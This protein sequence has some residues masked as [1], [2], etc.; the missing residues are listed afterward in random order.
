MENSD[1]EKISFIPSL[2]N[3]GI[4]ESNIEFIQLRSASFIKIHEPLQSSAVI[5]LEYLDCED[6]SSSSDLDEAAKILY[7]SICCLSKPQAEMYH[8]S[9][10]SDKFCT[11][12]T[13]EYLILR[14]TESNVLKTPCLNHEC[15][16][17]F[18][19]E[20][21]QILLPPVFYQ[22]YLIFKRNEELNNCP[23][24]R[25]CPLPDCSGFDIGGLNQNKLT[26]NK[27][28][29]KFCYYCT[30]PWH[31]KT[32]CKQSNDKELDKWSK[33]HGV[34][35][36]PNCRRKVQKNSGCDHMACVKCR[37]EWCWLCGEK[38]SG[39]HMDQ[40]EVKK[41]HRW[42]P[43]ISYILML[44]FSTFAIFF[45]P[46]I[47]FII[48]FDKAARETQE[49]SGFKGFIRRRW[50]SFPFAVVVGLLFLPLYVTIGPFVA[51]I[52]FVMNA[53]R[54]CSNDYS[55]IY[56]VGLFLGIVATPILII[57]GFLALGIFEFL[58]CVYLI[59]KIYV[60]IR[61]CINPEFL[62]PKG[63]YGNN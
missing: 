32:K 22:K 3:R 8:M 1:A 5:P 21:L 47:G 62:R 28:H 54:Q 19:D 35:Y 9:Q 59:I 27:C 60:V 45:M 41:T 58:G 4:D 12:C 63:G 42:N 20:E 36:C 26:C 14:V 18:T 37:Y 6:L 53:L 61:K 15:P 10:C 16:S 51:S 38:Y 49:R 56:C 43:P 31:L 57:L 17:E 29:Y 11:E 33:K 30:E 52:Y 7:C 40:C 24:L 34:K 48:L 2:A 13:L 44:L 46:V 25:W 55:I 39:G 50:V 23:F